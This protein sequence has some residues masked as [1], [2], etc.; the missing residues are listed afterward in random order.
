MKNKNKKILK[1]L[2]VLALFQIIL[3]INMPFAQSYFIDQTFNSDKK[4]EGIKEDK[5]S[6]M[7]QGLNFLISFFSIKQIGIVSAQNTFGCC[8]EPTT[9]ETCEMTSEDDCKFGRF[10]SNK[11]CDA[12]DSQGNYIIE[13]CEKKC[14]YDEIVGT[15]TPSREISCESPGK[16]IDCSKSECQQGCC[17]VENDMYWTT[18]KDCE[19]KALD[20]PEAWKPAILTEMEC[21]FQLNSAIKGS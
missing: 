12:K 20:N 7:N 3:L 15:C 11:T 17:L 13:E 6:F 14:C 16:F 5:G 10:V 1:L 18:K 8:V 4:I 9:H 21:Y 19:N 2:I